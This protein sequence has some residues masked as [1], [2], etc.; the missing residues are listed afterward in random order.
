MTTWLNAHL[1][2]RTS[3]R[4]VSTMKSIHV[5]TFLILFTLAA[6]VSSSFVSCGGGGGGGD[7]EENTPPPGGGGT[8]A[9]GVAIFWYP[10]DTNVAFGAG[11]AVQETSDHGFVV[12]GSQANDFSSPGDVFLMKTDSK[13]TAEWKK[14]FAWTGGAVANA[15]RQ[16]SD[17][18][19]IVV[20]QTGTQAGDRRVYALKT[21]A[22][23]NAA[24]GWPKTYGASE[25]SGYAVLEVSN[26]DGY[27]I[28]GGYQAN[29]SANMYVIRTD[30]DGKILW[31]NS[32]YGSFCAGGSKYGRSLAA[33]PDGNY[34]IGGT[35]GCFSWKSFLTKIDGQGNVLQ[36]WPKMLGGTSLTY[37]EQVYS[38][39]VAPD[40]F[41]LAGSQSLVSGQPP[42]GGPNNVLV[43]KT[44]TSGNE[45]WRRT[46]GGSDQDEARAVVLTENNTYLV[47]GYTQSYGGTVDPNTSW[48]Y[49]DVFMIRLDASGNALW[50]KVKGNKPMA[51]DFGGAGAAVSDG[52]FVVTG[53]TGGNVLLAKFDKNGDTINL[54]ATDLTVTIT[55]QGTINVG[56]AINVAS[57]GVTAIKGARDVGATVL[58]LLIAKLH[59]ENPA[60]FCTGGG[61][62]A[63]T[64]APTS[65]PSGT[66]TLSFSSCVTGTAGDTTV[67]TGNA[68]L[69]IAVSSGDIATAAYSVEVR[70]TS[71]AITASS[72]A[73][74]LSQT[75][76]GSMRFLRTA[77]NSSLNETW[78][79]IPGGPA[80]TF[81]ESSGTTRVMGSFNMN[82]YVTA[83]GM[84]AYGSGTNDAAT[85]DSG[86]GPLT[87]KVTTPIQGPSL[88]VAPTSG[89]FQMTAG[90]MSQLTATIT[91]GVASLAVDTNGDG[92]I[93]GTVSASWDDELD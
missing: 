30:A 47:L 73:E 49:Q 22:S 61:T 93:D 81:S 69:S 53:S 58:D 34:V 85:V 56:N 55:T 38:V 87:V 74:S 35:T 1:L 75:I 71:I 59:N 3:R 43:I 66:Y 7:V 67:L 23:G 14:R 68:G 28:V 31:E 24:Q 6:A 62:Y 76:T 70:I 86:L 21:D 10:Y 91:N 77:A 17:G 29:Q 72:P 15:V 16:T 78:A 88:G 39:A 82:G 27:M 54:G 44:D 45:L 65:A 20:G 41:V 92:T 36:G 19:Y 13:G 11:N 40:G 18:G 83:T 9:N 51:S 8:G 89:V 60:A 32:D 5:A 64:P 79:S 52:G 63:I 37:S 80:L 25:S 26:P 57:A 2:P 50:Q 12:A 48:E 42:V 33:T 46:Y 90:D 4:E 84:Y